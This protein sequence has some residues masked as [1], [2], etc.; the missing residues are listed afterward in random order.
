MSHLFVI[1]P[2]AQTY[3]GLKAGEVLEKEGF[4]ETGSLIKP[5]QTLWEKILPSIWENQWFFDFWCMYT[6]WPPKQN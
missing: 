4:I 3:I 6:Y 2:P 5:F 1:L